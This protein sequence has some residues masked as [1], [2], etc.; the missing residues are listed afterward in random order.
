MIYKSLLEVFF[1]FFIL[2]SSEYNLVFK[3]G[4][5]VAL[6]VKR[7]LDCSFNYWL[8]IVKFLNEVESLPDPY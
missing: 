8:N 2:I 5:G 3:R 4:E 7:Y 1:N 6:Q